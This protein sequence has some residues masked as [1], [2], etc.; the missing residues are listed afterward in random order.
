MYK[1]ILVAYDGTKPGNAALHQ[2]AELA[3]LCKAEL[4]VLAI[5]VTAGG[6]LLDPAVVSNE[7]LETCLLYTSPS[8]RD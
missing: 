4:H 8:P 1:K 7:L 2:G 3:R 6:L 5:V